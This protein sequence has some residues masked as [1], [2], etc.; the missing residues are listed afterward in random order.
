MIDNLELL[1]KAKNGDDNAKETL[2]SQN[3]GLVWSVARRFTGRGYDLEDLFQLGCIGLLKCIDRFDVSY[4]VCFSTYAV[5]LIQGEIRR[6]IRDSGAIKVSR[7]LKENYIKIEKYRQKIVKETGREPEIREIAAALTISEEDIIMA[8]EAAM[9]PESIETPGV[10]TKTKEYS[11]EIVDKV[12]LTE[13]LMTLAEEEKQLIELRY[14]Q[15]KTQSETGKILGIS[16]VQVSRMERK[17]L[18]KLKMLI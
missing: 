14:F 9:E 5:P 4:G 3:L 10:C 12:M 16:Q 11:Q 8:T 18:N 13:L 7:S 1:I 2:V 17:V 15:D 6:F